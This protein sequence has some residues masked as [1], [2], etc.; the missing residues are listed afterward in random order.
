MSSTCK[1]ILHADI[2]PRCI[3]SQRSLPLCI[4]SIY[5]YFHR[6]HSPSAGVP[7]TMQVLSTNHYITAAKKALSLQLDLQEV[8]ENLPESPK[9]WNREGTFWSKSI[10]FF[11]FFCRMR[12]SLSDVWN[13][14]CCSHEHTHCIPPPLPHHPPSD[15]CSESNGQMTGTPLE[16]FLGATCRGALTPV[17]PWGAADPLSNS[18][19]HYIKLHSGVITQPCL[20]FDQKRSPDAR[21]SPHKNTPA[22]QLDSQRTVKI[23]RLCFL[24]LHLC[25]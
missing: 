1:C 17:S 3:Q 25:V 22:V 6:L 24:P 8:P 5:W 21:V 9:C 11:N 23:L 10:L 12:F 4:Q 7:L 13:F 2:S 20:T 19:P 14:Y 16:G 18:C 15:T